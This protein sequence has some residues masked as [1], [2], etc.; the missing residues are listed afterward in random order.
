MTFTLSAIPVE[1]DLRNSPLDWRV[2]Q[3]A[4]LTITAGEHTNL[5]IDPQGRY[6][7]DNAPRALFVPP[8]GDFLLSARVQVDFASLFDAGV[9]LL[10]AREGLWAKL[11][12]EFSPQRKPMIVSVVT[13][14]ISDDCN[15]VTIDGNQVYLRIL[16][17]S[18]I[19]AF[20]FSTDGKFWHMA[21]YF[22]LGELDDLKVGFSSQSPRGEKCTT[23]FTEIDYR[24]ETLDDLRSGE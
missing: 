10:Y 8:E 5:F 1:L 3:D 14:G 11:C 16:R 19:F 22:S 13:R 23:V 4:V 17:K 21:R 20:H 15:S 2:E 24:L 12:F 7:E 6:S 18:E 9:L